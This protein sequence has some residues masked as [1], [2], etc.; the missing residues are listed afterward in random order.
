MQ[1]TFLRLFADEGD[2]PTEYVAI[3]TITTVRV[4]PWKVIVKTLEGATREITG[5]DAK[6]VLAALDSLSQAAD[7][8]S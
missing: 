5:V 4:E 3:S 8:S 2:R 7:Y 6:R 1:P